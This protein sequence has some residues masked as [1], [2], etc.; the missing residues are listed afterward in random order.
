MK[1]K[2]LSRLSARLEHSRHKIVRAK[3]DV[4]GTTIAKEVR[5]A[6]NQAD[7]Q[8]KHAIHALDHEAG[9]QLRKELRG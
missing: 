4:R 1:S 6:L 7:I 9:E 3:Q 2:D 5:E 8:L